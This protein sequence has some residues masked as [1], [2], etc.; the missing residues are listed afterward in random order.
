M[1]KGWG[2]PPHHRRA[3]PVVIDN[4]PQGRGIDDY[5][6]SLRPSSPPTRS[7]RTPRKNG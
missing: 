7:R 1:S 4:T 2:W 6:A 5:I 3:P